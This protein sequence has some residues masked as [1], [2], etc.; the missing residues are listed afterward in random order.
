MMEDFKTPISRKA[1][2]CRDNF[3]HVFNEVTQKPGG[4]GLVLS[5]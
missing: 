2:G 3:A 5:L 4:A 1:D